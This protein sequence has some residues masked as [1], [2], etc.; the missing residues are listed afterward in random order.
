MQIKYTNRKRNFKGCRKLENAR[1]YTQK[2]R[3]THN[4]QRKLNK[5][6]QQEN[7]KQPIK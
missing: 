3:K 5:I 6:Y 4:Y 7:Q 2:Q 1:F